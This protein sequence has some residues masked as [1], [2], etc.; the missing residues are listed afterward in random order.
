[1]LSIKVMR[2]LRKVVRKWRQMKNI[3]KN[4]W[5]RFKD[6][7]PKEDQ[8]K[9]FSSSV[10]L[11]LGWWNRSG[12]FGPFIFK[13]R[14]IVNEKVRDIGI[15]GVVLGGGRQQEEKKKEKAH[16]LSFSPDRTKRLARVG[17]QDG[18]G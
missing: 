8:A 5:P 15:F 11:N 18:R 1:M 2:K 10:I 16:S 9:L 6:R 3:L 13:T 4:K 7:R 14:G 12:H 17:K